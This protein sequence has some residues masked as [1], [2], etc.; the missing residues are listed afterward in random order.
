MAHRT[1]D[2]HRCIRIAVEIDYSSRVVE[3][4]R[5]NDGRSQK[6]C[7]LDRMPLTVVC[8][9]MT[10]TRSTMTKVMFVTLATWRHSRKASTTSTLTGMKNMCDSKSSWKTSAVLCLARCEDECSSNV[11]L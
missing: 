5:K 6:R 9:K 1:V 8:T 10:E 7:A 4:L 3:R 2:P 11:Q